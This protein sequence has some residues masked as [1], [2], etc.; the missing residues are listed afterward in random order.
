M[1]NLKLTTVFLAL[2]LFTIVGY[3]QTHV[4]VSYNVENLFDTY[5]DTTINDRDFTP[6]G[7]FNWTP[8]KYWHKVGQKAYVFER[9]AMATRSHTTGNW[10]I[11]IGLQEVENRS[12]LQD[13]VNAPRIRAARYQIVHYDS[14]DRRGVDVAFLYCA[15]TIEY[16]SSK[17]ILVRGGDFPTM[18]TRDILW[19]TGR[20]DTD[21]FHFFNGH[22][23]SRLGG[24]QASEP[25]RMLAATI[26]RHV[27]DSIKEVAPNHRIVIMGDF[28]DDPVNISI[29]QGLRAKNRR[30]LQEGDLLNPFYDMFRSGIGTLPFR[31]AWNLFDMIIVSQ[32]M[33]D[34]SGGF[35]LMPP[36]SPDRRRARRNQNFE[37]VIFGKCVAAPFLFEPPEAGNRAGYTFRSFLPGPGIYHG[38]FSDHLPVYIFISR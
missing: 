11:L 27:V 5:R 19:F 33:I 10:P 21:T 28:N 16:I 34:G 29:T 26:L 14:P 17:P 2:L 7:R 13:L 12:V 1:K 20:I 6:E 15:E 23:P 30:N 38:G 3:S 25:R 9:I 18:R 32:N 36:P 31:G 22:W 8:E 24:Q 37:G 4:I 35:Q